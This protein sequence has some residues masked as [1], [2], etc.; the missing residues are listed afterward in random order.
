MSSQPDSPEPDPLLG[1]A[2]PR[3]PAHAWRWLQRSRPVL[4]TVAERLT[5][6]PPPPGF[7]DELRRA[8]D[9]DPFTRTIV[10]DVIAE[11][12]FGGRVPRRQPA[13]AS[14]DR[15]LRWW[16]AALAGVD[17][18]E[19][20]SRPAGGIQPDLFAGSGAGDPEDADAPAAGAGDAQTAAGGAAS[21]RASG[22]ETPA[23]ES[24]AAAARRQV[25]RASPE[26]LALARSLRQLLTASEGEQVP[27]SAVRQLI[28]ELE[29]DT[30]PGEPTGEH[31]S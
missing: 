22:A 21:S 18:A 23:A 15:G 16:A 8:F 29:G 25:G 6:G 14:W 12:A 28:A 20:E 30:N 1:R 26:R 17:V 3:P 19:F 27:A 31:G 11:V 24:L 5:G 10:V 4:R 7:V 2:I 13:G 9:T